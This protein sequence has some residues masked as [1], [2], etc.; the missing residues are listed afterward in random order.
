MSEMTGKTVLVTGAGG[1]VGR[2]I[3][4]ALLEQGFTVIAV[5]HAFDDDLQRS[6]TAQGDRLILVEST[7]G[8]LSTVQTD[9]LV[10]GAAVTASPEEANQTPEENFRANLEP[11]LDVLAW[12]RSR[13][14]K[15][16]AFISSG[17]VFLHSGPGLITED[18]PPAHTGL[19]PAAKAAMEALVRTY[20]AEYGLDAVSIRLGNLYGPGERIRAT[21][22][23]LSLIG[24][25]IRSALSEQ[26]VRVPEQSSVIDWTYAPD[27]G[28]AV[29]ALLT[30]PH[31]A[32]D[33]Y[34]VTSGICHDA[35]Q[36]AHTLRQFLPQIEIQVDTNLSGTK[37]G[38]MISD[39]FK[40][41]TGFDAWTPFEQGLV[42][43]I[44]WHCAQLEERE[45][46]L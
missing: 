39:R 5:D 18:T 2:H 37:R 26:I 40:A 7:A 31:L 3:V 19:Y 25:M 10:H 14:V 6:W 46:E 20:R 36:I 1:F 27:I 28:R 9:F 22:P 12:A 21:R 24:Q 41:D 16:T 23:R 45:H 13:K 30:A 33:L 42:E 44:E 34:H 38:C 15:R 4:D 11:V 17:A 8:D 35:A 43:T 29:V 32:H